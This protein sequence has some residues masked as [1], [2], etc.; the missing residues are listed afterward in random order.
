P[1]LKHPVPGGSV[2]NPRAAMGGLSTETLDNAIVRGPLEF[3]SLK[4]CVTAS[5]FELLARRS[6]GAV[7]MAKAI[8]KA[9]IWK[10][11]VPGT[12]DVLLVPRLPEPPPPEEPLTAEMLRAFESDQVLQEIQAVL[13]ERR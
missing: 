5:D 8:T 12:V 2:A 10:H 6:S 7:E 9:E 1:G 4:R 13:D 11:A 3:N